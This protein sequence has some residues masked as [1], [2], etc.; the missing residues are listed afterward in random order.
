MQVTRQ[1]IIDL[2]R[3]Q[4]QATVEDL[5]EWVELTQM[6]VRHHLKVLQAEDLIEVSHTKRQRKPGRP[7]QI[8]GLTNK[9]RK[10]YPQEYFQLTDLLVQEVTNR[11]G[12]G[13]IIDIFNSLAAR[14]VEDAPAAKTTQS[15]EERLDDVTGFLRKKGYVVEWERVNGQYMVYHMDCPYRQFA[16]RHQEICL[17]DA[18]ILEDTL[19]VIPQRIS[20]IACHDD[21]CTYIIPATNNELRVTKAER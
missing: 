15:I 16:Q 5:A 6:A 18:K 9:A 7:V 21:K 4:G 20:C 13:G 8:Y 2:L 17:M 19:N 10:L 11:I 1:R 12:Q 14:L 3:K